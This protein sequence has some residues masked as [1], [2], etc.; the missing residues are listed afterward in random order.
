MWK[1]LVLVGMS[2]IALALFANISEGAASSHKGKVVEAGKGKLT[3][4]DVEGSNQHT[5]DVAANAK[6]TCEGQT[7]NLDSLQPGD[8][9]TVT[10]EDGKVTA[11]DK[12]ASGM[13][14][15]ED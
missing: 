11:I 12:T 7:C 3:M 1:R 14:G 4:T 8:W 9:I 5:H 13:G 15:D 6:V 2:F 10:L